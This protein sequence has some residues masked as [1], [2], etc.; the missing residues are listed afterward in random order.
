MIQRIR[1]LGASEGFDPLLRMVILC[2]RQ[3]DTMDCPG[4]CI[5]V[6][7]LMEVYKFLTLVIIFTAMAKIL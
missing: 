2:E 7:R 5:Q 1:V 4:Y 6:E 3:M